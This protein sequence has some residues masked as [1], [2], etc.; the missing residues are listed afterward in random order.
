[1]AEELKVLGVPFVVTSAYSIQLQPSGVFHD[2]TNLGKP[3]RQ[4]QLLVTLEQLLR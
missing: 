1:M 2:M 4:D 3:T